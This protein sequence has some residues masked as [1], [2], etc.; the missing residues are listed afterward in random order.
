MAS[1]YITGYQGYFNPQQNVVIAQGAQISEAFSCGGF[2][3]SGIL[4]PNVFTGTALT[5]LVGNSLDGFQA[6]GQ[7]VFG[8]VTTDGDTIEI[9]GTELT[10]VDATPGALEVLIGAT[11]AETASNLY[12]VLVASLDAGI[13]A[14]TYSLAGAVVI[15]TAVVHGVDGNAYT[16]SKSSTDI[17]LTPSGGFLAGGGFRPLYD[18]SNSLVSMT[19]AQSRCYA[20]DPKNFQGVLFLQIKSGS[21]ELAQRTI[22]CLLKGF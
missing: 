1:P 20:V 11:A 5:F 4:L 18:A 6:D 8:G 16:F 7:I 15:V 9:N 2:V 3:L 13:V 19:V 10:F 17:T 22:T 21:A 12:D 14:C